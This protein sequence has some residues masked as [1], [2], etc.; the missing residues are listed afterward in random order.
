MIT[1]LF[2]CEQDESHITISICVKYVKISD[3][4]FYI[5]GNNF[6]FYLKPY[7]L[8]LF[9]SHKLK[10]E[11]DSNHSVYDV[12]SSML[13]C[14]IEKENKGELFFDLDLISTLLN[15]GK[16]NK[17]GDK[18]RVMKKVEEVSGSENNNND[19]SKLV[20]DI[21][22]FEKSDQLN[23]YL[24]E[25]LMKLE[26]SF[27][28][29]CGVSD[30][31]NLTNFAPAYGFNNEYR[32]VFKHRE[33][34]RIE[35]FDSNP[36]ENPSLSSGY[37][38]LSKSRYFKKLEN[39]NFD[40]V[41]ERYV[42]DLFIDEN[43]DILY[44]NFLKLSITK[45]LQKYS[46]QFLFNEKE[47]NFLQSIN[48][49]TLN[50]SDTLNFNIYLQ[51]IDILFAFVYDLRLTSFEH[52]SESG[53]NINKLSSVLSNAVDF[54]GV[55]FSFSDNPPLDYLESALKHLMISSYRR[56]LCYPLFRNLEICDL[57]KSDLKVLLQDEH[58][59][60]FILKFLLRIKQIFESSEPRHILNK[61]YIDHYI[62]WIQ[63]HSKKDIW[64]IISKVL[65]EIKISKSDIKL[66]LEEVEK[67]F[68]T[69]E[70]NM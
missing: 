64:L 3:V 16:D 28:S 45:Y 25:E 9:F 35:L 22:I 11:S 26:S 61:I 68:E 46:Q 7:F 29:K 24:L 62:K 39:E 38:S 50:L 44:S 48:K 15:S 36:E 5:E 43:E 13:V 40:F 53:W 42:C 41:A 17:Q 14:K 34:E 37:S 8:N 59:K 49:I 58:S 33:E 32:E 52:N 30:N 23:D 18:L 10:S 19:E 67:S 51:I 2:K 4:D 6:K 20:P 1:P 47:T 55:F 56:V 54:S 60:F 57:I 27:E 12:D 66:D 63:Y 21:M 31:I 69:N 70:D 65:E